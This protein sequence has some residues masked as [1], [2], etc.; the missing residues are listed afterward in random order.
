M[1]DKEGHLQKADHNLRFVKTFNMDRTKFLDWAAVA[2]FYTA[3]H[4]VDAYLSTK[5]YFEFKNH[6]ERNE[7]VEEHLAPIALHYLTLFKAGHDARYKP[8]RIFNA[9][10]LIDY[11]ITHLA[12]IEE[13]ILA[14]LK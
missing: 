2:I 9:R 3:C 4:Y 12:Q 8:Y 14:R 13:Y 6:G 1:S 7:K 5:G 10:D 11:E